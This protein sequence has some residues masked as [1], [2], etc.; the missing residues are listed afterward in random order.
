M[1]FVSDGFKQS[2]FVSENIKCLLQKNIK[3][4]INFYKVYFKFFLLKQ[5]YNFTFLF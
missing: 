1:D 2:L 5:N 4:K 3:I